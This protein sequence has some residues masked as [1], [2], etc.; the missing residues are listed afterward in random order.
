MIWFYDIFCQSST[1]TNPQPYPTD[2][3]NS[4]FLVFAITQVLNPR[5]LRHSFPWSLYV[6]LP[7][8]LLYLECI[9]SLFLFYFWL[10]HPLRLCAGFHFPWVIQEQKIYVQIHSYT[11][12]SIA[13]LL[14]LF[15]N[16][17]SSYVVIDIFNGVYSLVNIKII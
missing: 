4:C 9:Y 10:I 13:F 15:D 17:L 7:A 1:L 12:S 11:N 2:H 8:V 6:T 3:V 14:H 16:F 5:F